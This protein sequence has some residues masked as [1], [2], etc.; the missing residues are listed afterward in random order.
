MLYGREAV[1]FDLDGTL[2]DS[3]GVWSQ[4]DILFLGKYGMSVP[5]GLQND[6]E[7]MSYTE[8]AVYFKQRFSLT[9]SVEEIKEIWQEMAMEQYKTQVA[10]KPG[11]REFL[12]FL[13][14]RGIAMAVAS[15]N[16]IELI[17]A[18]LK[19]RS[20]RDY[21]GAVI[22]SCEVKKGKPAP[23]VYLEAARRLQKEPSRCLVFEDIVP[24]IMAGKNAGMTVCAVD[25]CYSRPQEKE[26]RACADYF[27]TDYRQVIHNTY[28]E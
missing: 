13:K 1:I 16:T 18:V 3:M 12:S 26:K 21:F 25:D 14:E 15:S 27:I 8:T 20:I 22:T 7:G 19:S 5:E 28:E 24:G 10:L 23:D 2:V 17:E 11:V 6:L 9:E 4:V